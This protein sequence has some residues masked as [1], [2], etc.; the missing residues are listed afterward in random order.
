MF[1]VEAQI[2]PRG[3]NHARIQSGEGFFMAR[4]ASAQAEMAGMGEPE[5][6]KGV[7]GGSQRPAAP[8]GLCRRRKLRRVRQAETRTSA[9]PKP[10]LSVE[11]RVRVLEGR[12]VDEIARL[13]LYYTQYCYGVYTVMAYI[14]LWHIYSY[15]L[16]T[17]MAYI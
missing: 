12:S 7:D 3:E 11:G 17:I 9:T 5:G 16:Y 10:A 2:D 15:G 1:R 14:Y 13:N 4:G 6:R 8:P